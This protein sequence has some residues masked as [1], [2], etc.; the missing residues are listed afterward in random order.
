MKT[1]QH[2]MTMTALV[3]VAL[4]AGA[5]LV[6]GLGVV[7]YL[8]GNTLQAAVSLAMPAFLSYSAWDVRHDLR[9]DPLIPIFGAAWLA[10]LPIG[11]AAHAIRQL[12]A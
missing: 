8:N 10:G 1:A 4:T 11:W 5:A 9:R 3:L 7:N 2:H 12:A 6:G